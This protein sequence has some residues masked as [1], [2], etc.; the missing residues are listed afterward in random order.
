[1]SIADEKPPVQQE[2]TG[3]RERIGDTWLPTAAIRAAAEQLS[4]LSEPDLELVATALES[5]DW[6]SYVA[7]HVVAAA[8]P[9]LAASLPSDSERREVEGD[10]LDA[11]AKLGYELVTHDENDGPCFGCSLSRML[12]KLSVLLPSGDGERA[13]AE[14]AIDA[15]I[16]ALTLQA[17]G[18]LHAPASDSPPHYLNA[19]EAERWLQGR[20]ATIEHVRESFEAHAVGRRADVLDSF[21]ASSSGET[22]ATMSEPL[23]AE[24]VGPVDRRI[25]TPAATSE[26]RDSSSL[27]SSGERRIVFT[28]RNIGRTRAVVR[29]TLA[30]MLEPARDALEHYA[31]GPDR[32][33]DDGL[34]ARQ[35][36]A[37][38]DATEIVGPSLPAGESED[39]RELREWT[40]SKIDGYGTFVLD[41]PDTS[42]PKDC[43]LAGEE[44]LKAARVRVR[45]IPSEETGA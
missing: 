35:A 10:H 37:A 7:G 34:I 18:W 26:V 22:G 44:W 32:D 17:P 31:N 33:P 2:E 8:L 25:D 21:A 11:I 38:L 1:M 12:G 13:V 42:P 3:T 5:T 9:H 36:L 14:R 20:D 23:A 40:I 43:G 19:V 45:E 39:G 29:S 28:G 15:F 4:D 6:T 27:S 24:Y 30:Y 41:G 16:E